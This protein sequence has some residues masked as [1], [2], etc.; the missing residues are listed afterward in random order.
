MFGTFYMPKNEMPDH[1][2]IA[3]TDFPTSFGGQLLY[4]FRRKR[5]AMTPAE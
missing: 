2:G 3:E 5:E 1:Y 4:P